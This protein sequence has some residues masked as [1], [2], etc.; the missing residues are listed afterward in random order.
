VVACALWA[1][2]GYALAARSAAATGPS[3]ADPAPEE[4]MTAMTAT[5]RVAYLH[6]STGEV[7]W[8]GGMPRR[9]YKLWD[10]L[11]PNVVKGWARPVWLG[12]VQEFIG[13]W[14][15]AHGTRYRITELTYPATTGG[16]PWAN[17]PYD[18][19]NL[20]VAH[21][22]AS[23]DRGELNLDDLVK[24]YDIIVFK[25]CFSVS[26]IEADGEQA[27]VSS[28]EQTLANYKL[29]YQALKARLH[30]FPAK[31]FIVWTGP[32]LVRAASTPENARRAQ[33]FFDWVKSSWDQKGDNIF[34]WDFYSLE[35]D[36][37]G[38]LDPANAS[39]VDN[40]HPR[41]RFARTV[42]PLI[43]RRIVDVIE[44]RG[45]TASFTGRPDEARVP[46]EMVRASGR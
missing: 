14:N 24:D 7:V 43:G 37:E 25:H 6:H 40:S 13:S 28:E 2:V 36:Q 1:V 27:S 33:Q 10:R 42:A 23:R 9:L 11:V 3:R 46:P 30:Q 32:A 26:R 39:A 18:Y 44:G 19:W 35:A 12:G 38:F 15:D 31:R 21:S 20:W 45:D 22:G 16:Y 29:Q 17:D 8:A 41:A 4:T 5:A 34:V